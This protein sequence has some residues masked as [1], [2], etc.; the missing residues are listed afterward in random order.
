MAYENLLKSVEESALEKERELQKNAKKQADAIRS[1]AKEQA[2]EIQGRTIKEAE[3]SAAIERNKQLFL[4]KGAIKEQAL[5][6]REKVFEAA[7]EAAGQRLN[8]LRQD[9][10]YPAVF[11]RLTEETVSAMGETPFV[12]HVDRRDLDL[13]KNTLAALKI[14]CEI[15][16][17]LEC[18]G[19]LVAS[20][21]DGHITISNTIES[22]LER[23]REHKR[24]EIYAVLAGG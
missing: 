9:D 16:T 6:S 18:M 12:V 5:K 14:S 13:C 19:G 23:V 10:T 11:R 24:L 1:A 17:D 15:R 7:F 3:T 21:P 2:E 22:R 8:R 4:A 20:S